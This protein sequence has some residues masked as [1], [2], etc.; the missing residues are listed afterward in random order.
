MS[1]GKEKR[2]PADHIQKKREAAQPQTY[3][4]YTEDLPKPL[5]R[6]VTLKVAF[7]WE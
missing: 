1:L 5:W 3:L 2:V 7:P 4:I 6:H